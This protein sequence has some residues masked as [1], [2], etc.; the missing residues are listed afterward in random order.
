VDAHPEKNWAYERLSYNDMSDYGGRARTL[1][2]T[3]A[4][5]GEL[6]ATA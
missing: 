5:K 1:R 4:I 3:A 2:R 6:L